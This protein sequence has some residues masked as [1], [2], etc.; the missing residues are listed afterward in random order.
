M[1]L[2]KSKKLRPVWDDYV[3]ETVLVRGDT[4][5]D[6]CDRL[7]RFCAET[8]SPICAKDRFFFLEEDDVYYEEI[9]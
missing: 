1:W 8:Y 3:K 6:C 4:I 9:I 2:C 5:L 7:M